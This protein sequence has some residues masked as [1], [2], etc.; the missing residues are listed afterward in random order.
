MR[1]HATVLARAILE[2]QNPTYGPGCGCR[3]DFHKILVR[4]MSD[5]SD[6][7]MVMHRHRCMCT[8]MH[9]CVHVCM[10]EVLDVGWLLSV[11]YLVAPNLRIFAVA[12]RRNT[13]HDLQPMCHL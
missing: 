13:E 4:A 2:V 11:V 5:I 1:L 7:V 10:M 6:A 3:K 12:C 9:V 8:C